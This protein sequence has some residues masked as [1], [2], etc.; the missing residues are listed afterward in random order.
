MDRKCQLWT[1]LILLPSVLP[2][3][4]DHL[5]HYIDCK[6]I[7]MACMVQNIC[8]KA[9]KE[10]NYLNKLWGLSTLAVL[11][12]C[13]HHQ[14]LRDWVSSWYQLLWPDKTRSSTDGDWHLFSVC[15]GRTVIRYW[16]PKMTSTSDVGIWHCV[17]VVDR[18]PQSS[19]TTNCSVITIKIRSVH[20]I[21]IYL[22]W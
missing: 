22:I 10:S 11:P 9:T 20:G 3:F 4:T 5:S 15:P 16:S 1:T 7:L 13:S 17:F 18:I 8:P 12:V 14:R 21:Y 2:Q 6:I 19:K